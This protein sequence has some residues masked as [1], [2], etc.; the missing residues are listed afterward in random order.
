VPSI[1]GLTLLSLVTAGFAIRKLSDGKAS[2]VDAHAIGQSATE[3]RFRPTVENKNPPQQQP[4]GG[5]GW[6]LGG[7]FS[8]GA[9]DPPD[10]S[11][12]G[13]SATE[14]SRPIHRVYV[15]GFWMDRTDVTNQ[16][17][18]EFVQAT[19]YITVAERKPRARDFPTAPH[20]NLVDGSVVFTPPGHPVPLNDY[21]QWWAYIRGANWRHPLG[22]SSDIK[23]KENYPVVHVAYQDAQA[24]AKW[25][26]KR[27][28]TEAEWEFAARG[29]RSGQ[30][31]VWGDVFRPSGKWMANTHLGHFPNT[32]GGEDGYIGVAPV[33]QYPANSYG[34]YDMAGNVWQWTSDWNRPDYH[35][36]LA[37]TGEVAGD[38]QG[39]SAS[40]DPAE[41]GELKRV[42]R[43]GS[44][45]CT[46]QDCSRNMVGTRGKGEGQYW[47]QSSRLPL[48]TRWSL[49]QRKPVIRNS[50][51]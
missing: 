44:F 42:M 20:E 3:I 30:P 10:R 25:A 33:S 11:S 45:L 35:Q 19:G 50:V 24:H 23:G 8:M 13:M 47:H 27:L 39:P 46:D 4:S 22:R 32:E 40:F 16:Q 38:P 36:E 5:M 14:D 49:T 9:Q 31:F 6:I 18:A 17:F 43:G 34:L 29:G 21:F 26:G 7:T 2:H 41:P 12:V 28:P 1:L 37:A 48:P 51:V 15:D